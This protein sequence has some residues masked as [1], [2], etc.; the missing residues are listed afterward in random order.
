MG[1]CGYE[2]SM[3]RVLGGGVPSAC[4]SVEY[5]LYELLIKFNCAM[6]EL[7]NC[8]CSQ[9]NYLTVC[10]KEELALLDDW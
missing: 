6:C 5:V 9:V 8:N 10:C 3:A 4:A 2:V 1:T 7:C